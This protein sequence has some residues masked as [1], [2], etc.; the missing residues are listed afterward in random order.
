MK[1]YLTY[2]FSRTSWPNFLSTSVF[3]SPRGSISTLAS[4]TSIVMSEHQRKN[5]ARVKICRFSRFR[6]RQTTSRALIHKPVN[7]TNGKS[8]LKDFG[9][10]AISFKT[11][12]TLSIQ[13]V[14]WFHLYM[15]YWTMNW[16]QKPNALIPRETRKQ[17]LNNN[18]RET[19]NPLLTGW[20]S[21]LRGFL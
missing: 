7:V 14:S 12:L 2:Y 18:Q 1:N 11:L 15:L 3:K 5:L 21:V 6:A 19:T 8:N 20:I 9:P 17:T 16:L 10:K 4:C 13:S